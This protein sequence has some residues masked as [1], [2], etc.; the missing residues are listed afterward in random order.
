MVETAMGILRLVVV[1]QL[2]V[3]TEGV[4][5]TLNTGQQP[6][7]P[8]S[9]KFYPV[10]LQLLEIS[11]DSKEPVGIAIQ[12]NVI[13]D[14]FPADFDTVFTIYAKAQKRMNVRFERRAAIYHLDFSR[15]E[16]Q[17]VYNV[18]DESMDKKVKVWF[19]VKGQLIV[20]AA[21]PEHVL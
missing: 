2:D 19:V 13:E 5:V 6:V 1:L 7:L 16:A 12:D 3:N 11:C 4:I 9:I 18:L 8:K 20:D 21:L 10:G 14:M 15:P 17:R